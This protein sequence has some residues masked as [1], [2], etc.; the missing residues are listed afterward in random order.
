MQRRSCHFA[1]RPVASLRRREQDSNHR[2]RRRGN[3]V[4]DARCL[5]PRQRFGSATFPERDRRFESTSPSG[6]SV[7]LPHPRSDRRSRSHTRKRFP[8]RSADRRFPGAPPACTGTIRNHKAP[9][10][11]QTGEFRRGCS[12]RKGRRIGGELHP[13][14]ERQIDDIGR[15]QRAPRTGPRAVL[16]IVKLPH[17]VARRP[18]REAG[19]R[20]QA[21]QFGP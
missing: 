8:D 17:E 18:S 6:E 11:A 13:I 7:S 20:P 14:V 9:R 15:H 3:A 12:G 5:L 1:A 10:V 2:S 16:K 21:V 4:S 19:D